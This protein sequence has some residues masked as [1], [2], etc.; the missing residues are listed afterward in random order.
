MKRAVRSG[1]V[2]TFM[3]ALA[4]S[5][6][7]G[8]CNNGED[9]TD[10]HSHGIVRLADLPV[11]ADSLVWAAELRDKDGQHLAAFVEY[12]EVT[13]EIRAAK[14]FPYDGTTVEILKEK[15]Q[16]IDSK[17]VEAKGVVYDFSQAVLRIDDNPTSM[18]A[19]SSSGSPSAFLPLIGASDRAPEGMGKKQ[20]AVIPRCIWDTV[21][22]SDCCI[23]CYNTHRALGLPQW[24]DETACCAGGCAP[25]DFPTCQG[26]N[27]GDLR[28][29]GQCCT[30]R[31]N[32]CM[33]GSRKFK[34]WLAC[35][36]PLVDCREA[37][38]EANECQP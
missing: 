13:G 25:E 31:Y 5:L 6:A 37:C 12:N 18:T 26:A 10:T 3:F 32:M 8:G 17:R 38:L 16:T 20:S 21:T 19:I 24:M 7:L 28:G 36:P 2:L 15:S 33:G 27:A 35:Y 34:Q 29:C 9:N 11:G 14:Y 23:D 30:E 22:G 4:T 1:A